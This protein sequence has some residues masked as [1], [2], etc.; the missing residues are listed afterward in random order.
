MSESLLA[1]GRRK[2]SLAKTIRDNWSSCE[3]LC[4]F[5]DLMLQLKQNKHIHKHWHSQT[6][7]SLWKI[8]HF[9]SRLYSYYWCHL[10]LSSEKI[11]KCITFFFSCFKFHFCI[12]NMLKTWHL[13]TT[14]YYSV[15]HYLISS[16]MWTS[17]KAWIR[18]PWKEQ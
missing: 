4:H 5:V 15:M 7:F 16:V 17:Y 9:N 13:K 1:N 18:K 14:L 8:L 11:V 3:E 6:P 2:R 10:L 12:Q